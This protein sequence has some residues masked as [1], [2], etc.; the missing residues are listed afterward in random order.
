MHCAATQRNEIPT[1]L[2]KTGNGTVTFNLAEDPV[3]TD[4]KKTTLSLAAYRRKT[5]TPTRHFYFLSISEKI[6]IKVI[7]R[8]VSE[9]RVDVK[10]G[11][12][13][14]HAAARNSYPKHMHS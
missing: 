1:T 14:H 7:A 13:V 9:V 6:L 3:F 2:L 10:T 11:H 5:F 4:Y 8:K 12:E